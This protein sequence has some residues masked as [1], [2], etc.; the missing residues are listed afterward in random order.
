MATSALRGVQDL[1][2]D[3]SSASNSLIHTDPD[4]L[5]ALLGIL[6][7]ELQ[8]GWELKNGI[9]TAANHEEPVQ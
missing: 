8:I 6:I 5:A 3:A 7:D 9:A 4:N 2:I 1:L